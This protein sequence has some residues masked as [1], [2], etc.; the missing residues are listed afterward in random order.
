[1]EEVG[2]GITRTAADK[3]IGM[4]N[5]VVVVEFKEFNHMP[6]YIVTAFPAL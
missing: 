5:I 2:W 1:M 6:A 4:K 3:P